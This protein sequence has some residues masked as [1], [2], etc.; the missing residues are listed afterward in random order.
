MSLL[1]L[2]APP[3]AQEVEEYGLEPSASSPSSP[4]SS[5]SSNESSAPTNQIDTI[6]HISHRA[7]STPHHVAL[8]SLRSAAHLH[9][10]CTRLPGAG[11][12]VSGIKVFYLVPNGTT[13]DGGQRWKW[14]ELCFGRGVL[15]GWDVLQI[16]AR[17]V[18]DMEVLV[19][20]RGGEGLPQRLRD[21]TTAVGDVCASIAMITS[22]ARR[23]SGAC[24][25]IEAPSRATMKCIGALWV[26][27]AL[28][29]PAVA[30]M[31][32]G[33][34]TE[35]TGLVFLASTYVLVPLAG[36]PLEISSFSRL[37][38]LPRAATPK[39][40]RVIRIMAAWLLCFPTQQRVF[41][42]AVAVPEHTGII[43]VEAMFQNSERLTA[44]YPDPRDSK[45]A[46]EK[47]EMPSARS[48]ETS[49]YY[50][51]MTHEPVRTS[52]LVREPI[53]ED[54]SQNEQYP[55]RQISSSSQQLYACAPNKFLQEH[56][57]VHLGKYPVGNL[58]KRI[59]NRQSTTVKRI[60]AKMCPNGQ[61]NMCTSGTSQLTKGNTN[62]LVYPPRPAFTGPAE[63]PFS[64]MLAI[65]TSASTRDELLV[66]FSSINKLEDLRYI[67]AS[68]VGGEKNLRVK[69]LM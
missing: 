16:M 42:V 38:R 6:L 40:R 28:F 27:T 13:A 62:G 65:W 32:G 30:C 49:R 39:P 41:G 7:S 63:M 4:L 17:G 11:A 24:G 5:R 14:T 34:E 54:S 60:T 29:S 22:N 67:C 25:G 53:T 43:L 23:G 52:M 18:R 20:G 56:P 21:V 3:T 44:Q 51:V 47:H 57:G 59:D 36:N 12:R 46:T 26:A 58:K 9:D 48:D 15:Y 64:T 37:A 55:T 68:A 66:P 69:Y 10:V 50:I 35:S 19:V 2:L 31:D 8:A 33:L 45:G 61:L 1:G